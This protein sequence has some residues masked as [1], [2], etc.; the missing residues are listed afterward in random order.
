MQP[1]RKPGRPIEYPDSEIH[2]YWRITQR[3]HQERK[4]KAALE[5]LD[6]VS[7][8]DAEKVACFVQNREDA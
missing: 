3:A 8:D 7:S 5:S 1:K 4:K 2:E 6:N